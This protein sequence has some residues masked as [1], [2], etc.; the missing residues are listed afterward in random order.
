MFGGFGGGAQFGW[1]PG[2]VPVCGLVFPEDEYFCVVC[3]QL[4]TVVFHPVGDCFHTSME[5]V[6]SGRCVVHQ[7]EDEFG[8]VGV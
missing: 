3:V 2:I 8:V 5:L 6:F 4:E 1:P 7:G